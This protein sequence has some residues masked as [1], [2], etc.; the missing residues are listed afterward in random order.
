[1]LPDPDGDL[2]KKLDQREHLSEALS[3]AP[4]FCL[5]L[6]VGLVTFAISKFVIHWG[7]EIALDIGGLAAILSAYLSYQRTVR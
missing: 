5:A 2:L 6:A 3:L 7:A 4:A 1:M